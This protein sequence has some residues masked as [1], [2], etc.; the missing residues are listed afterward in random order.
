MASDQRNDRGVRPHSS[1]PYET[2]TPRIPITADPAAAYAGLPFSSQSEDVDSVGA[3]I[4]S[5]AKLRVGTLMA[6]G[7]LIVALCFGA[8]KLQALGEAIED[9]EARKADKELIET[10]LSSIDRRLEN[11]ERFQQQQ[12]EAAIRATVP[13]R[14][15]THAPR[16]E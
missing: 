2:S 13:D 7:T 14:Q 16:G 9:A 6:I 10:K 12:T 8:F 15:S 4:Q 5:V 1:P 11:I 3:V